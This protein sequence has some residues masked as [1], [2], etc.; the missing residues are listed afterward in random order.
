V[1]CAR[2]CVSVETTPEY[3]GILRV[4][5]VTRVIFSGG[6][7]IKCRVIHLALERSTRSIVDYR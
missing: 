4:I 2:V 3:S 5:D 1:T 6:Y 7:R